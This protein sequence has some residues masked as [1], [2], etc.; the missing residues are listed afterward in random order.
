MNTESNVIELFGHRPPICN[1]EDF[2]TLL[3]NGVDKI[4]YVRNYVCSQEFIVASNSIVGGI[5]ASYQ[6]VCDSQLPCATTIQT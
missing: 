1:D 6:R 5:K 4:V 3:D 2:L